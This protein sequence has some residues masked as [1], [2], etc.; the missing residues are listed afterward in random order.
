MRREVL[1]DRHETQ[2]RHAG[3]TIKRSAAH[4][5]HHRDAAAV[6]LRAFVSDSIEVIGGSLLENEENA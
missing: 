1:S 4:V 2:L 3:W 6:T 5:E